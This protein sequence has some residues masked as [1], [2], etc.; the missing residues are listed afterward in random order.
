MRV[1]SP[2]LIE[3]HIRRTVVEAIETR[4]VLD[5]QEA[6]DLIARAHGCQTFSRSIATDV[7]EAALAAGVPMKLAAAVRCWRGLSSFAAE[8]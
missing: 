3:E 7:A 8:N 2:H 4:Q 6:A 5:V 1:I